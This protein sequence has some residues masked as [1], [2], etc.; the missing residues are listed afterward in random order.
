[1]PRPS[2]LDAH[3]I[4]QTA[5]WS[6]PAVAPLTKPLQLRCRRLQ[7]TGKKLYRY[8]PP[9]FR[10][11]YRLEFR[12][13]ESRYRTTPPVV[14][15]R[16]CGRDRNF[17]CDGNLGCEWNFGCGGNCRYDGARRATPA[18]THDDM[19]SR[20]A[21]AEER[22]NLVSS[23]R[24]RPPLCEVLDALLAMPWNPMNHYG[25]MEARKCDGA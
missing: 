4:F 19:L 12:S 23:L 2:G 14:P 9:R 6:P 18:S 7:K 1:L 10:C 11:A 15:K 8:A 13:I 24:L 3:E 25:K 20:F 16:R 22:C 5:Y 17:G 21:V